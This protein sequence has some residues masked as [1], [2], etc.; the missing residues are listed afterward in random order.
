MRCGE[1]RRRGHALGAGVGAGG[2]DAGRLDSLTSGGVKDE[3]VRAE[4][5][6]EGAGAP[7]SALRGADPLWAPGAPSEQ[8]RR[9]RC[10]GRTLREAAAPTRCPGP[11]RGVWRAAEKVGPGA[12]GRS[13]VCRGPDGGELPAKRVNSVTGGAGAP[14]PPG[15][16]CQTDSPGRPR[17]AFGL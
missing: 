5:E 15:S 1:Q 14:C 13:C 12:A 8:P 7:S 6:A 2:G 17:V 16:P 10:G 11:L 4:G 3:T 9:P